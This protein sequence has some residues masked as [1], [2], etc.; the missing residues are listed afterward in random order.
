MISSGAT[1]PAAQDSGGSDDMRLGDE[2]NGGEDEI[3]GVAEENGAGGAPIKQSKEE[4]YME[5][6]YRKAKQELNISLKNRA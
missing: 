4:K 6:S 3:N 1:D 5:L 2:E